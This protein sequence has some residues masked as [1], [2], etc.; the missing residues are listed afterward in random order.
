MCDIQANFYMKNGNNIPGPSCTAY[1]TDTIQTNTIITF[2]E[3]EVGKTVKVGVTIIYPD[4]VERQKW[5]SD[6]VV[7]SKGTY[8]FVIDVDIARFGLGRY[9][10]T[11]AEAWDKYESTLLCSGNLSGGYCQDLTVVTVAC[12]ELQTNLTIS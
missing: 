1:S 10:L 9:Q 3:S 4:G 6:F 8:G 2:T 11:G 7:P 5:A 12:P